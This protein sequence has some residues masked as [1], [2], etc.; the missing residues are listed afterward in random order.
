MPNDESVTT[1]CK[2]ITY[3]TFNKLRQIKVAPD[4]LREKIRLNGIK[5]R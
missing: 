5:L 1:G 4:S 2:I 3:F